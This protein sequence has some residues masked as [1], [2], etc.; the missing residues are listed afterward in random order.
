MNLEFLLLCTK[1]TFIWYYFFSEK[2]VAEFCMSFGLQ[3]QKERKKERQNG[4]ERAI[5]ASFIM[6]KRK[7]G[8]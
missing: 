7:D 2:R 6:L 4:R 5:E 3:I 1:N 8:N